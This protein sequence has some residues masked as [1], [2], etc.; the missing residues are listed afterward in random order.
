[1]HDQHKEPHILLRL[2]TDANSVGDF[3]LTIE[4]ATCNHHE[5]FAAPH[6]LMAPAMKGYLAHGPRMPLRHVDQLESAGSHHYMAR[7]VSA[8]CKFKDREITPAL[9][10]T[11]SDADS[12]HQNKHSDATNMQPCLQNGRDMEGVTCRHAP[13][14][15]HALRHKSE[16][17]SAGMFVFGISPVM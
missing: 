8:H 7:G 4:A 10:G 3:A 16:A 5:P 15:K 11:H 9:N 14:S 12:R 6:G 13:R 2:C 17:S 1:M